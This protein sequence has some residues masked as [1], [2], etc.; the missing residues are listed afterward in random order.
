MYVFTGVAA[1]PDWKPFRPFT[2]PFGR[3]V[4]V[5]YVEADLAA[6]RGRT[7]VAAVGLQ[8]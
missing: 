8:T 5:R 1:T 2:T 3:T 4:L 6:A 7:P